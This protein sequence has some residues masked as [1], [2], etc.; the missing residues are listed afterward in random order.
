[1]KISVVLSLH[2]LALV[3]YE[4]IYIIPFIDTGNNCQMIWL[5]FISIIE[6]KIIAGL[7]YDILS[8]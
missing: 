7:R 4:N 5:L 3:Y 6:N 1:M 2:G 8:T